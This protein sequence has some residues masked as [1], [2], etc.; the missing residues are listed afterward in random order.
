MVAG[1]KAPSTQRERSASRGRG[2]SRSE[3]TTRHAAA[4]RENG[5]RNGD[6]GEH[7]K[8][9]MEE[10][11]KAMKQMRE[12]LQS[13]QARM[14]AM[15]LTIAQQRNTIAQLK[16]GKPLGTINITK[17]STERQRNDTPET[18]NG[19]TPS[20][21]I[22]TT[23]PR[24]FQFS[25]KATSPKSREAIVAAARG[26]EEQANEDEEITSAS[27]SEDEDDD[28]DSVSVRTTTSSTTAGRRAAQPEGKQ[29]LG[30]A[31]LNKRI[32]QLTTITSRWGKNLE[33]L[34]QR[35]LN[36]ITQTM[37]QQQQQSQQQNQLQIQQLVEQQLCPE[38]LQPLV[39]AAVQ[40]YC[41]VA[42]SPPSSQ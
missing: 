8:K 34:E 42:A 14:T 11:K 19:A 1:K 40:R 15:Q 10:L 39:D 24:T 36:K 21:N 32:R 23:I 33:N 7:C 20:N 6:C 29:P 5:G 9:A 35:L 37:Q 12:T 18:L 38:R 25:A 22:M 26:L 31:G 30:Y 17:T 2:A 16:A 27:D 4:A 13:Q 28:L 3:S 41:N